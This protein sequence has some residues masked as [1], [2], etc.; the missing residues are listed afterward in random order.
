M[1]G[2]AIMINVSIGVGSWV[3]RFIMHL[4]ILHTIKISQYGE[5]NEAIKSITSIAGDL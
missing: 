2:T 5:D 3:E 4:R 1:V